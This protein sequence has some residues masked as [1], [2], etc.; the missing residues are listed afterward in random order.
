[1]PDEQGYQR[2]NKS[3]RS[4]A[5]GLL[6][7]GLAG[8]AFVAGSRL[9]AKQDVFSL[10]NDTTVQASALLKLTPERP[11]VKIDSMETATGNAHYRELM[12]SVLK[13]VQA[14]YVEKIT[15][16]EET[17][18]A[19]GAIQGMLEAVGDP[20]TRFVDQKET[21]LL[22]D[23]ASGRFHGIG[24][25]LALK[26]E[27]VDNEKIHKL[28]VV[29]PMIGSPAEQA[30]LLPGDE[31]IEIGGKWVIGYDPGF[32]KLNKAMQNQDIDRLSY[33][34]GWQAAEDKLKNGLSIA[35]A[36]EELTTKTS[37]DTK[38]KIAR[39]GEKEPLELE[40]E[41]HDTVVDPVT[42]RML[43][44]KGRIGYIRVAQFSQAAVKEFATELTKM[45][46]AGA[47]GLVLDLRN[48]PGGLLD[49]ATGIIAQFT[50]GGNLATI[51]EMNTRRTIRVTKTKALPIPVV[52][53]VNS[54]T[55][56]VAELAA[57][58]L[59]EST[60]ATLIGT[61][62]FGD[63]LVQTP[64]ILKD[65]SA[66]LITTGKML[67][68]RGTDFSGVGLKPDKEVKVV[69][70]GPDIQLSEAQKILQAKI[71]RS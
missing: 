57:A 26:Q 51:R 36:L 16:Q 65:K 43:D 45:R 29:T 42:S 60:G 38:L 12:S 7:V 66:A 47:Q 28:I 22:D 64:L 58:V 53:L 5:T 40:L 46:N 17:K 33:K 1:M 49:T 41:Y 24:A 30:G 59:R 55:A 6:A 11:A 71:G 20:D 19:H 48:S 70:G 32:A 69:T 50:G 37:G 23:A 13:L 8:S 10:S 14:H 56:S 54:G 3:Y 25:I 68:P 34:K 63:G 9:R 52:V 4:I 62:T 2:L 61:K 15:P 67:T 21:Q 44:K 31:I 18:M 39:T 27:T 35:D